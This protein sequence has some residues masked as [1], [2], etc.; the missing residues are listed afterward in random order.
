MLPH[1]FKFE[2]P[3]DSEILHAHDFSVEFFRQGTITQQT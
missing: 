3:T 2:F 1:Y